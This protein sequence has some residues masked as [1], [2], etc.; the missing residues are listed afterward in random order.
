MKLSRKLP[1]F[2][3]LKF[4]ALAILFLFVFSNVTGFLFSRVFAPEAAAQ[5]V[6]NIRPIPADI[7]SSGD[8]SID[9]LIFEAGEREGVD[10]R[11]IHAV[12]WQESRYVVEARSHAG[13]TG[14]MQ[15]MP[16]AAER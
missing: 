8:E 9:R 6:S 10:P 13:A 12:V 5:P 11:F 15:L 1:L 7:P 4:S 16:A 3:S 14:L 2:R